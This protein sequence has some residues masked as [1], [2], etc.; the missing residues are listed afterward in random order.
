M[1]KKDIFF[2]VWT[3]ILMRQALQSG[4]LEGYER[5]EG[6]MRWRGKE[7]LSDET[8]GEDGAL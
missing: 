3:S 6:A 7:V 2:K 4:W 5:E 8:D 1:L